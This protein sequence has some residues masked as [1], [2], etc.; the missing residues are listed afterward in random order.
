HDEGARAFV[1]RALTHDD[2]P[3]VR[4]QA[5]RAIGELLSGTARKPGGP[6]P[7]ESELLAALSDENVR[8]R[9]GAARTLGLL[10]SQRAQGRLHALLE[11]DP[12]PLVRA[13]AA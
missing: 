7:F 6:L 12:W 1:A 3:A 8:V 10:V 9:E 13:T 11:N 4:T 2:H 5:A